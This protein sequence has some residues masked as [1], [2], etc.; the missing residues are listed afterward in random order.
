MPRHQNSEFPGANNKGSVIV[1]AFSKDAASRGNV[2]VYFMVT[3]GGAT[4]GDRIRV[5]VIDAHASCNGTGIAGYGLHKVFGVLAQDANV[6][7]PGNPWGNFCVAGW[8]SDLDV[9]GTTAVGNWLALSTNT[10]GVGVNYTTMGT[11]RIFA[12]ALGVNASAPNRG[13]IPGFVLPYRI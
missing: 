10:A 7:P 4:H 6:A 13:S 9:T 5:A 2:V 3:T 8:V 12:Y 11:S 1:R